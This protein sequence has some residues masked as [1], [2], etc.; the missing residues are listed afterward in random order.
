VDEPPKVWVKTFVVIKKETIKK[1][2][3]KDI[4]EGKDERVKMKIPHKNGG[5][6]LTLKTTNIR[7][8]I[9]SKI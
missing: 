5:D 6:S 2:I 8:L 7:E 4:L 1:K 3:R 9:L